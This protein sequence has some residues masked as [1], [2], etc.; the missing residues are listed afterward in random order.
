MDDG[1]VIAAYVLV[2]LGISILVFYSLMNIVFS[3]VRVDEVESGDASAEDTVA[4]IIPVREDPSIFN[5][6]PYYRALSYKNFTVIVVDDSDSSEFISRLLA[7]CDGKP[8]TVLHRS[9]EMR[10]GRKGDAIN[11]GLDWLH[12]N[13]PVR[14]VAIMDADHRP[15]VDFLTKAVVMAQGYDAVIGYQRHSVGAKG[16]FGEF[17]YYM[18][19]VSIYSMLVR[20][21][22]GMAPIFTGSVGLFSYDFIYRYRFSENSITE[23]WD[24]SMRAIA[25]GDFNVFVSSKLYADCAVPEDAFWYVRQQIRWAKGN[26]YDFLRTRK[27]ILTLGFR[28]SIGLLYQ[29]LFFSQGL[30]IASSMVYTLFFMP[31]SAYASVTSIGMVFT[32]VW[33]LSTLSWISL[34]YRGLKYVEG[35]TPSIPVLLYMVL[36]IY[37]MSFVYAYATILGVLGVK[38][39]KVTRRRG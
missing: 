12:R 21:K 23:D 4:V 17:Y 1:S 13:M 25:E 14:W 5:V 18:N 8:F 33:I 11:Y 22:L 2:A 35:R 39:W 31:P 28:T 15:P 26:I 7:E 10:H 32:A 24:L 16:E 34:F 6:I 20:R 9:P 3:L 19:A 30:V 36:D 29:G 37:F 38:G 27:N